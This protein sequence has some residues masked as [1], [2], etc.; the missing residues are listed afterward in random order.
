MIDDELKW[1][2]YTVV[3]VTGQT[4]TI[5]DSKRDTLVYVNPIAGLDTL[6]VVL[7]SD[8]GSN[9]AQIVCL[10]FSKAIATLSVSGAPTIY[11]A[12]VSAD[13]GQSISIQKSTS[14][15]WTRL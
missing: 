4:I 13:A 2:A 15:V 9:N 10:Q 5:A 6:N 1:D 7:P 11:D 12:P 3:P 14:N 8:A